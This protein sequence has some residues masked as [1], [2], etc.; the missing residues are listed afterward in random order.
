[1]ENPSILFTLASFA[2]VIGVLV[3]VHEMGHYLV[4]RAFGM[5]VAAFAVG[6]G[7]EIVGWTDR[8]GTRWKIGWIP[9][10]GYA[11]FVGDADAASRPDAEAAALPEAE[12]RDL[13]QF[14]PVWQRA[15]VIVAG[16]GINFL[17]AVLLF[18]GLFAIRGQEYTPPRVAAVVAGSPAATAGLRPGDVITAVDGDRVRSFTDVSRAVQLSD[19]SVMRLTV[20][21]GGATLTLDARPKVLRGIDR[22]GGPYSMGRLG[23]AS[24]PPVI[25][26]RGPIEA[27]GY[28]ALETVAVTRAGIEGLAQIVTGR[29]ELAEMG[30]PVKIARVSGAVA[31]Y[32]P[33]ALVALVALLSINL[34]FIN[35]LP[36]PMLDGGHLMLYAAE[37]VRRRPLGRRATELAFMSGAALMLTL[38]LV[39]TWNDLAQVGV[40]RQLAALAD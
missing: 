23:V 12:K 36:I 25:V 9:L 20:E 30:G 15:L 35:L 24:G 5:R 13:F 29:R 32:G 26:K 7:R 31:Q 4:A 17:F 18:A 11:R 27:I 21:R 14:R 22:F 19:G 1:M 34:G 37:A 33:E 3:F 6:F 38:M 40:W 10:G 2:L 39:L 16:P 8:R 28:G